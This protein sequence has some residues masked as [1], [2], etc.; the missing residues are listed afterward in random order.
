MFAER[1]TRDKSYSS[2][3]MAALLTNYMKIIADE[4]RKT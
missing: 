3:L 2:D 1:A 4:R